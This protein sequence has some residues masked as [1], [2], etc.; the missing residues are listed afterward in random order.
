MVGSSSFSRPSESPESPLSDSGR[1]QRV[2]RAPTKASDWEAKRSLITKLYL[3]D[4]L[5]LKDV[6][7]ILE[8]EYGFKARSA[9]LYPLSDHH[10]M[11][12]ANEC[13]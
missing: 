6:Q 3:E 13:I 10:L 5:R 1:K 4:G 12:L 8:A 11:Y 2:P 7:R 9:D